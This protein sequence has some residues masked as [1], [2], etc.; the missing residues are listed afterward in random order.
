M[1]TTNNANLNKLMNKKSNKSVVVSMD[2]LEAKRTSDVLS[3][4]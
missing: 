2:S 1:K 4:I 3:A